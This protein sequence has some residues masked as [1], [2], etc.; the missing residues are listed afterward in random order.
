MSNTQN[1]RLL[2]LDFLRGFALFGI[3]ISNIPILSA[4]VYTDSQFQDLAAK[5]VKALYMFLVTGKFFVLFSF[6]FGYGFAILLQSIETKGKDPK[7]IYLRRLF[8]L[9]ILGLLHALFLFEGDILVSYS[10]LGVMLYFLKDK[11]HLWKRYII[12]FWILSFLTYLALGYVSYFS[13]S[14][15]KEL[16]NKLTQESI[17]N[18]LGSLQQ[19][20]EQQLID[21]GLAFPFILLFNVPTAA[22][23]FLVGLW[24]GKNQIFADPLRIWNFGKGK[25]RYLFLIGV[26]ANFGYTVSQFYPDHFFLGVLPSSLLA[27]GGVSFA[28]LYVYGIINLLF[29]QKWESNYFVSSVAKA[30]SMSLTNYLSQSLICTFIFDGWGLGYFSLLHPGIVLLLTIPIYGFNLIFSTLWK[31]KFDLGPMEWLLRKWTYA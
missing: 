13:F 17:I 20:F 11:S 24:A 28:L 4:P 23:M 8:G 12:G 7:R 31:S 30:G 26:V 14:D 21:Y 15:G 27:F 5:F 10:I 3:L 19:N 29:I 1:H 22:M 2:L 18:H 9:F 25:K 6:V 16:A